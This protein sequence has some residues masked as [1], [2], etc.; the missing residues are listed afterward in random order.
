MAGKL[1]FEFVDQVSSIGSKNV[2]I[3]KGPWLKEDMVKKT[4][5]EGIA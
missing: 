1:P 2:K 4:M 5:I 3:I